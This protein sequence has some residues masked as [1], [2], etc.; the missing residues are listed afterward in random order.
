[1]PQ[2][3]TQRTIVIQKDERDRDRICTL[4]GVTEP[5]MFILETCDGV[6]STMK[7]SE[8][9]LIG[10]L[11]EESPTNIVVKNGYYEVCVIGKGTGTVYVIPYSKNNV[12]PEDCCDELRNEIA[13]IWN[14]INNLK[15]LIQNIQ[16]IINNLSQND[17]CEE[18]RNEITNIWQRI[19]RLEQYINNGEDCCDELRQEITNI[20]NQITNIWNRINAFDIVGGSGISVTKNGDVYTIINTAQGGSETDT[21]TVTTITAGSGI[22]VVDN[23]T[24]GNHAYTISST[25]GGSGTDT[26]TVTTLVAGNGISIS[27]N[28]TG[29]NHNYTITNTGVGDNITIQGGTGISVTK[30]GDNYTIINTAPDT[31]DTNT[32]TTLLPGTGIS[33]TDGGTGGNHVYTISSTGGGGSGIDTNTITT[34]IAGDGISITD[35]GTG[36]NHVYTITNTAQG[37]GSGGTDTNTITTLV[38]GDGIS[39]TNNGTGGNY[40]YTITAECCDELSNRIDNITIEGGTGISVTKQGDNY[41]II[42]TAPD[43]GDTNTVT[44]IT[45]GDNISIVDNGTG[46][47]HNYVI[48]GTGGG[49][50]GTDT[51]TITT[52]VAGDGISIVDG[53]IG[54]NHNYTITATGNTECCDQINDRIDNITIE[55]G[56]GISVTKQGDNYTIINTSPG[57]DIVVPD[58][59]NVISKSPNLTV[60]MRII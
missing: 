37:G 25:G 6:I 19:R 47:N 28:G 34:L 21:N 24:G 59:V 39:I 36:G 48:T 53:G 44:T 51:N 29:G 13:N 49:S 35:G 2:Q 50:G 22:S 57:S 42:N 38:A 40:N 43:T 7:N 58:D 56:T 26:N 33:I 1:M 55:G 3:E 8:G 17:C 11:T 5:S 16:N 32:V 30:Q 31:G 15:R 4:W 27:D 12:D 14:E 45:A 20:K 9:Q 60:T 18:L 10:V 52:L 41:T 46:G 23:G 54:G